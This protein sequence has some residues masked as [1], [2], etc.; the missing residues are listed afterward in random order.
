[1]DASYRGCARIFA[2]WHDH[3]AA[4]RGCAWFDSGLD[5]QQNDVADLIVY[6]FVRRAEGARIACQ[7][8]GGMPPATGTCACGRTSMEVF[9][10]CARGLFEK[11][12]LLGCAGTVRPVRAR[13]FRMGGKVA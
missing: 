11:G 8:S 6:N 4:D 2:R 7:V 5:H 13:A 3:R 9:G 10:P 12:V 1:M